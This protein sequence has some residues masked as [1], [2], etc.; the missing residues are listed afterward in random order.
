MKNVAIISI[1]Q[2]PRVDLTPDLKKVFAKDVNL[3]EFGALDNYTFE[4]I[5][6]SFEVLDTDEIL[7]SRMRD[8][9]QV[10]FTDSFIIPKIQECIIE[11]EKVCDATILACTGVFPKFN[12]SKLFIEPQKIIHGIVEKLSDGQKIGVC[13]PNDKQVEQ[14]YKFWNRSNVSVKVV[15]ASPYEQIDDVKYVVSEAF[16]DENV[17]LICLDC[18]GYTQKM[19]EDIE[20][21]TNIPV[22]LPRTLI[23]SILNDILK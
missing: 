21:L 5:N 10:K 3:I 16:K 19:K 22:V 7:V 2:T 12:H 1:G 15:N 20:Q 18:I 13:V 23:S 9:R 14:A 11:A 17:L 8:G 4:E 6:N